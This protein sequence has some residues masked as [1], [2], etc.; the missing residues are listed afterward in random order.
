M[1]LTL[2]Q[3]DGFPMMITESSW[4]P[5][6]GYQSEGP[7]L[8][9]AYQSL[10]GIDAYYWFATG[11]EDWRQPGSANGFLPSEGKWVC[12]TPMLM[13]Q[14]PAAALM[15]RL[16]YIKQGEPVVYEQ[17]SLDDL[18]R[19]R[20]P[21]IAEDAG[22]DPN[23]DKANMS[24]ESNV[25]DGV[26]PLAYLVGPV[27]VKYG[28]DPA[29][30]R[31]VDLSPYLREDKKLIRSI[32]GQLHMDYGKGL[33]ALNAPKAQGVTGFLKKGG[34]V[35][36]ADVEIQSG[37]DYATVLVVAMD[38]KPLKSSGKILV[39]VGTTE[40]PLG[41]KTRPAQVNGRAGEEVVS[42]GRA[43]WMI[44]NGDVTLTLNNT[45]IT[46]ARVL[47]ANGMPVKEVPLATSAGGKTLKFP[48]DA[49]Y[50][51]LQ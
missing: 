21:I 14:W 15:Y 4:V 47:D 7:F 29:K 8:V 27:V 33:C 22:Y 30:S 18:W 51:V 48:A 39:Q 37:N 6:Q 31:A 16:G 40:R 5:P 50:V 35:K 42:F 3:V 9:A 10:T 20:M 28:G 1:P 46:K 24:K 32:T 11:E 43:P 19:R 36:C 26:N 2:K 23:R 25:K 41:W 17:R 45:K 44:V 12:A 38:D 34:T 49:L 13:G